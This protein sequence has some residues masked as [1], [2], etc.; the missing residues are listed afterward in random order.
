MAENMDI[1]TANIEEDST[2]FKVAIKVA[3]SVIQI[4]ISSRG[5]HKGWVKRIIYKGGN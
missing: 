4:G 5:Y 1:A 2:V 3:T